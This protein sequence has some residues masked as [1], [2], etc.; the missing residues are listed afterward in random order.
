MITVLLP[1]LQRIGYVLIQTNVVDM[2]KGGHHLLENLNPLLGK[3]LG[4]LTAWIL[5]IPKNHRPGGTCRHAGGRE[6]CVHSMNT[7]ITLL[8]HTGNRVHK[9]DIIRAGGSTIVTA[10]TAVRIDHHNSILPGIG[11][12]H[13]AHRITDWPTTLVT[14]PGQEKGLHP[15]VSRLFGPFAVWTIPGQGYRRHLRVGSFLNDLH[16]DSPGTERNLMLGLTGH[17][18]GMASDTAPEVNA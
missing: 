17:L 2:R 12:L 14:E 3:E 13:W 4:Y 5:Q 10:D 9:S 6:A 8:N 11:R 15:G 7:E 16:P 1:S 18:A